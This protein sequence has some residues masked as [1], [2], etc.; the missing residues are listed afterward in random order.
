MHTIL[1]KKNNNGKRK[2]TIE[3]ELMYWRLFFLITDEREVYN[4][5]GW[6]DL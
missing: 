4:T 5:K 6:K 2:D 1:N 3:M